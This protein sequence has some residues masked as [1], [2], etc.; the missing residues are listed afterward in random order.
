MF[1]G[2]GNSRVQMLLFLLNQMS[3]MSCSGEF[4]YLLHCEGYF[5]DLLR[6]QDGAETVCVL[7][8]L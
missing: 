3:L 2:A 1:V 6:F 5:V 7:D 8:S 4:V